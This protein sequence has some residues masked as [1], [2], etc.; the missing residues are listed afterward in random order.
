MG[1]LRVYLAL[2][3][4][5]VHNGK[6]FFGSDPILAVPDFFVISGFVIALVLNEKY[7]DN[8]SGFYIARY[9][10]LWPTYAVV[11]SI[12]LL[13]FFTIQPVPHSPVAT[14]Y[15]YLI[16]IGLA[17]YD[18]L[19]WVG[20]SP[21]TDTVA[22]LDGVRSSG[23]YPSLA[24]RTPMPQ[25]WSVG[26]EMTFY[27]VAPLLARRWRSLAV[28]FVLALAA[29]ILIVLNFPHDHPVSTK[30]VFNSFYLFTGGML[31]YWGWRASRQM[32]DRYRLSP[33]PLASAVAFLSLWGGGYLDRVHHLLPD[34]M[35][36]GFALAIIPLFH[37][38]R[39]SK[40]D[41]QI[42]ELS[43]AIY[44][45]HV[46][47]IS[48]IFAGHYGSWR[49]TGIIALFT[50]VSSILLQILVVHPIEKLR[51]R[52]T[53]TTPKSRLVA[54]PLIAPGP[55]KEPAAAKA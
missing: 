23:Y 46:P 47:L 27:I 42:G 3:V 33:W 37:F 18:T 20:Y 30:S 43:Y 36:L 31:A 40:L 32:L 29:H 1:L 35:L 26:I 2:S 49:W 7:R 45:M 10:R 28:V 17:F 41:R 55:A 16:S 44:V 8:I 54:V 34:V 9:L 19:G 25:M 51:A 22:F 11:L 13:F 6:L 53:A 21:V 39:S 38:S 12:V 52:F 15:V 24:G 5:I 4:L 50:I 48:F 14:I